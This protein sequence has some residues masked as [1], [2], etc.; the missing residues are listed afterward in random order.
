MRYRTFYVYIA[1]SHN[2]MLYVGVT[3]DLAGRMAEHR[4][5]TVAGFTKRY[6]IMHL[7]HYETTDNPLSAIAREKEIKGWRRSKKVALVRRTNPLW[8]DL[9]L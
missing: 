2:R 3:N 1:A 6:R 5:G 4:S 9:L 7:V 8:I